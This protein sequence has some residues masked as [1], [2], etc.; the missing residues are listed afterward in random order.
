MTTGVPLVSMRMTRAL[1]SL[2]LAFSAAGAGVEG[3]VYAPDGAP[4]AKAT[5]TAYVPEGS[6]EQLARQEKRGTRPALATTKTEDGR[7][8][9]K[10]L[11]DSVIDVD[12]RADGFA[13]TIVRTLAGDAPLSITLQ[14]APIVE[15]RITAARK[16]VAGA[17]VVWLGQN[18][19]EYTAT[20]DENGRYRVPD[21][22]RWVREP[23]V[24]HPQFGVVT[25]TGRG[26]DGL[27]LEL[28]SRREERPRP[29]GNATL[30][31]VVKLGE[32]PLAGVPVL[33]QG[34]GEQFVPAV[35]V[36]TDAKGRYRATGLLP[37]RTFVA[38]A[39]GLEPRIRA[40]RGTMAVEQ[41]EPSSI[42]LSK[43]PDGTLDLTLTKAPLIAGRVVDADGKPVAGAQ[44]QVILAGRSIF[45]F[46]HEATARTSTDGRYAVPAPP[47][48]PTA[49]VHVVVGAPRRS[50]VRSK[51]FTIG[52][53]DHNVD[54]TLPPFQAVTLRVVDRQGKPVPNATL[55]F[56]ESEEIA[57]FR[58]ARALLMQ[59]FVTRAARADAAGEVALQLAPGSY[60]F[61]AEAENFQA[62]VT[63]RNVARAATIDLTLEPAFA[64]RGRVHRA[65]TG[66][67]S[68][69]IR[70]MGNEGMGRDVSATTGQDGRFELQGLAP[71]RYRL[72]AF[73][74]EE[75]IQRT[76]DAD[77]PGTVDIALPPAGLL[78]ARV[79]DAETREP[80]REFIYSIEPA[81]MSG[82][83]L[84]TGRPLMQRAETSANGVFTATLAAGVYR[85][86][87]GANGYTLSTPVEVRLS[88][89]EPA[90]IEIA[91]ERGGTIT[92]RVTDE[93]GLPVAGADVFV[94]GEELER[95]RSRSTPRVAPGNA[96]TAEDGTYTVTGVEPGT[97]AMTVR[98]EGFVPFRRAVEVEALTTIDVR[99]SRGLTIEGVV[100]RNGKPVPEVSVGATT[101]AVGGDH[102]PAVTDENG[103]FVLRGLIAAKYTV[104]A[105][106]NDMHAEVRDVDPASR[107]EIVIR[108]DPA[109]TG[110]I[111]GSVTGI[112][113]NL[114]GKIVR[115]AVFVQ[116]NDRGVEGT[117]DESGNYRIENAPTGRV[118][119]T[120]QLEATAGGRSSMRKEVEVMAGQP[121]RVDLDLGANTNVTG[122]VTHEG[123]GLAGVRVVF[124]NE[125]GIGGSATT[126]T[127]G[128][129]EVALPGP[130]TYQIFAHGEAVV[131]RHFQAVR[132]IRG[133]ETID[134][135]MRE[136]TIEGTVVDAETRQP[137]AGAI[138][139]VAP[140]VGG[141]IEALA[142]EA[143]AD[144]NGRFR[145]VTAASGPHR[146]VAS[147]PGYG[148]VEQAV[149]L[150]SSSP[151]PFAFELQR[152]GSL[153]V[154]VSDASTG[155]ALDAHLIL[156]T[157]EGVRM[158]V[159][160]ERSADGEW[161]V[162]SLAPGRYRITSVV[163]GYEQKTVEATAPG[164]VEIGM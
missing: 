162:F 59:P 55:A 71:G 102:Q 67:D 53:G 38:P 56:A 23:R 75:L 116:S 100:L 27:D 94:S 41:G 104:A 76:I 127:D 95:I 72:G 141:N 154:R 126:R 9:L 136:Q 124:A 52:S 107:K 129:Y 48:E 61:A 21:V 2:L 91:L 30:S 16:P 164:V 82:E 29:T 120:A 24:F 35:R 97:A 149:T 50:T 62:G 137:I 5:V 17:Y 7:F 28:G 151:R 99:L 119:V 43:K 70:V 42:D 46:M 145:I 147:A 78:R 79:V 130:G 155:T 83:E 110:V 44:V 81:E 150:G 66:V 96:R 80:V 19:V 65:G 87:A 163:H 125:H 74:H 98:K 109:P 31:G 106:S 18:D 1:L 112:P 92:G 156:A 40:N 128:T 20:T 89:R 85:V 132:Q 3:V 12:V 51:V 6:A 34:T 121:V 73:K 115:R 57:G 114:G 111:F 77:A 157:A 134:I 140:A 15:A 60:E 63:Q 47:F 14:P 68:V 69:I 22:R 8:A 86:S 159:R 122:R 36:V 113:T 123:K 153:R 148:Q 131:S 158:P 64:I 93:S 84:R 13:P 139:T 54:A 45:D 88:D 39:E 32:K 146:V 11:P 160:A 25:D 133:G 26:A 118:F 142:G 143:P 108:L 117:I 37:V 4:V 58:D 152:G 33:I 161:F 10:E 49:S 135:D 105:Y 90:D 144:P 138:V 103:R 101:A